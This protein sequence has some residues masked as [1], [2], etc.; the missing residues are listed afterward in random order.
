MDHEQEW[1]DRLEIAAENKDYG[2]YRQIVDNYKHL[3]DVDQ[4]FWNETFEGDDRDEILFWI[5]YP[6]RRFKI[7]EIA[8]IKAQYEDLFDLA[9]H[10][11]NLDLDEWE[12]AIEWI[13]DLFEES[14]YPRI[15]KDA[16]PPFPDEERI[17]R[18]RV[19]KIL[20]R[21]N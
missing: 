3:N 6:G 14:P 18:S 11:P 9:F 21:A 17:L 7:Y 20:E 13:E 2:R 10:S 15:V 19:I 8:R 16:P 5:N 1:M 12:E 4:D